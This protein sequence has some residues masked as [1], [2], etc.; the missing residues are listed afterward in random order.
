MAISLDLRDDLL[1]VRLS[2]AQLVLSLCRT[3]TFPVAAVALV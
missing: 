2:G 3:L 1:V